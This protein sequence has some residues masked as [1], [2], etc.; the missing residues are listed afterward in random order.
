APVGCGA[1]AERAREPVEGGGH[2]QPVAPGYSSRVTMPRP[3]DFSNSSVTMNV[4]PRSTGFWSALRTTWVDSGVNLTV[5]AP[6]ISGRRV[7]PSQPLEDAVGDH[8]LERPRV[9]LHGVLEIGVGVDGRDP[10]VIGRAVDAVVE[11][12]AA[13]QMVER[14]LA[15]AIEAGQ[16]RLALER[17]VI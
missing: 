3:P 9:R 11:Q 5:V 14:P 13:Q 8:R 15:R 10:A 17:D 12:R 6:G 4:S 7:A 2:P 1:P 16:P